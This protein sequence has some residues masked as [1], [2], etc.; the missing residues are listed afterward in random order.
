MEDSRP[1]SE[2]PPPPEPPAAARIETA[3]GSMRKSPRLAGFLS[4]FPGL[5]NIYNGLYLRGTTFF[6]LFLSLIQMAGRGAEEMWGPA[7]V[8]V[9]FFNVLDSYRQAKLINLG[10]ATDLGLV[11]QPKPTGP[12]QG[13]LVAGVVIFLVGLVAL[14][15]IQFNVDMNWLLDFWPLGLM[16]LGGWFVW[17]GIRSRTE[18][19]ARDDDL[20][21]PNEL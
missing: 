8:F 11:D 5:G 21:G 7:A 14:L 1:A 20:L 12:G 3:L 17:T 13:T 15:D 2:V 4:F 19:S 6:L 10:V 18:E 16:G 9:W